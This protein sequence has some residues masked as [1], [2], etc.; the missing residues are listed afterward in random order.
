MRI[1][2]LDSLVEFLNPTRELLLP[3]LKQVGDVEPFG[4]GYVSETEL[5]AGLGAFVKVHGSFDVVVTTE[6]ITNAAIWPT[7]RNLEA[8]YRRNHR[9]H[10]PTAHLR[11]VPQILQF[12]LQ[13]YLPKVA[14]VLETDY[15][16][17][18]DIEVETLEQFDL[19][20]GFGEQFVK[21]L[22]DIHRYKAE[23]FASEANDNYARLVRAH[24]NRVLSFPPFVSSQELD[25]R[26]GGRRQRPRV[27]VPGASYVARQRARKALAGAD[28]LA[29]GARHLR[30]AFGALSRVGVPTYSS[31]IGQAIL[32]GAYRREVSSSALAFADGSGLEW[33]VRKFFEIPA[34]GAALMCVPCNGFEEIGFVD[35]ESAVRTTPES[36]VE[37][38]RQLLAD[39]LGLG[40]LQQRGW[41]LIRQSHTLEAR[42]PVLEMALKRIIAG[43]F[44]GS[45]WERGKLVL[46]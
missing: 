12:A 36:I 21:P 23:R 39:P 45:W 19:L 10:F 44:S 32:R 26:P 6:H 34:Y 7:T 2:Y 14:I 18:G 22:S 20:V 40:Q 15:Y 1:L 3:L 33:P 31:A 43:T 28:L 8:I 37:D 24:A 5:A 16:G 11:F 27:S 13:S 17:I 30:K 35:G 29:P 4:P 9:R 38:A 46:A 42:G 25:M 41:D